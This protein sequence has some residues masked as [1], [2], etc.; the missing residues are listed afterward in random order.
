[1]YNLYETYLNLIP[2]I[3]SFYRKPLDGLKFSSGNIPQRELKTMMKNLYQQAEIPLDGRTISNHSGRVTLCTTLFNERYNDKTVINRSKHTSTAV[4]SYQCE[5]FPLQ[6]KIC[7]D[8]EP[9]ITKD[10]P[11]VFCN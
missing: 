8:L 10:T 1:M 4:H 7:A 3:G 5:Q 2:S 6:S 9:S 11:R